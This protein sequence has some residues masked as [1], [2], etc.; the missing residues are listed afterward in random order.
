MHDVLENGVCTTCYPPERELAS[1]S[2]AECYLVDGRCEPCSDAQ[3]LSEHEHALVTALDELYG[4]HTEAAR[5]WDPTKHPRNPPGS[6]GGG[7]F[8][9]MVDR[10]KDAIEAHRRG[11]GGDHP[12]AEFD[13]EQLRRV[14]K[15][16]GIEL[17]RGESRDSIAE[18]L[19]GHLDEGAAPKT[20]AK[21]SA[22]KPISK[23]KSVLKPGRDRLDEV[24]AHYRDNPVEY[25]GRR[26]KA[27]ETPYDSTLA[28][29]AQL[30]GFDAKPQVG[31]REDVDAAVASGWTEVWRGVAGNDTKSAAEI[32][33]DLRYGPFEPGRGI[34]GNG[35]YTSVR[36][37]TA[38]TFRAREPK[39]NYP[40]GPGPDFGPEDLEGDDKPD[41]MLRIAIDPAAKV[42]N[43]DDLKG[44]S[45]AWQ[46]SQG[47]VAPERP[48]L[49]DYGRF[50]AARGY[51]IL[52]VRGHHDGGFYPGWED[53]DPDEQTFP[54]ADQ[55]VILNR[56]AILIQR[57]E[58]V[59]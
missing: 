8:R 21:K 10:L 27:Y 1:R 7:R 6:P 47:G 4:H 5:A 23:V 29:I 16:R 25:E 58:D 50:A 32:N 13:R 22:T 42:V 39:T 35:I 11:E 46:A 43:L 9:S 19:L 15:A 37:N 34:Y 24:A 26:R 52:L 28:E 49:A 14:A 54:V 41:S 55:Y 31:T 48:A 59:A 18:K 44:D 20:P 30:Q 51:D 57:P 3:P 36:R 40:S 45:S 53:E 17:K 56:S 33:H 12:F 2:Q 38:E